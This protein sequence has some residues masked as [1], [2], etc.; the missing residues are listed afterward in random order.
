MP[1]YFLSPDFMVFPHPE[2]ADESGM[3]AV[4]G[5][6]SPER[7]LTAYSFGIF[8]WYDEDEPITWWSPDPRSVVRPG[9]VKVSKSMRPF[10]KKYQLKIDQSF[11]KVIHHCRKINRKGGEGTWITEEMEE[12]YLELHRLGYAHS[13][14]TWFEGELIGGLYGVSLGRCFFGESMFSLKSNASKF[15]FIQLSEWTREKDFLLIDCQVPN[16]HL[17]KMGCTGMP[18]F[19]Y[20]QIMRKNLLSTSLLGKWST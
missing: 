2:M 13:F 18:R 19:S 3:L 5:D 8:P 12:A 16:D 6:L 9:G 17:S 1:V 20:L 4:G 15:A 11:E 10:L 14:E 7:L